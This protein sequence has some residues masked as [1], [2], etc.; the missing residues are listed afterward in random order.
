MAPNI[1][2]IQHGVIE[3]KWPGGD[4]VLDEALGMA[5]WKKRCALGQGALWAVDFPRKNQLA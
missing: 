3:I 5:D 1:L 4:V 2:E